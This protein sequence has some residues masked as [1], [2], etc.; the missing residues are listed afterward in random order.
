MIRAMALDGNTLYL[1]G[2]FHVL[3][4]Q[5][6]DLAGA[7]DVS[8]QQAT[9]WKPVTGFASTIS[10]FGDRVY[11]GGFFT[12]SNWLPAG[13][14]ACLLKSVPVVGVDPGPIAAAEVSFASPFP[15]PTRGGLRLDFTLPRAGHV[16][17]GVYDVRGRQ[18]DVP[19]DDERPAGRQVVAWSAPEA[20]LA[21]GH[22]FVLFEALGRRVARSFVVLR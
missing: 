20:R 16:R 19:I 3:A 22:Y 5:T 17:V 2:N 13:Y 10:V 4:G 12:S 18:I 14:I 7:I 9:D 11:I 15:N 1:F 8:T 6:R 21:S